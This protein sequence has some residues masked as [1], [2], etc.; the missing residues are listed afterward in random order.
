MGVWWGY[1]PK[2]AYVFDVCARM[3]GDDIAMLD[4]QIVSNDSVDA[5]AA[6][7]K[8]IIGQDDQDGILAL[9]TL[10]QDCVT[11]EELEGFHGVVGEGND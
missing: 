6:I 4:S 1:G 2:E 3:D 8:I 9:F 10:D 7:I 11:S 5:R